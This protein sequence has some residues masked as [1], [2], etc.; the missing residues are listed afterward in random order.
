LTATA[1]T[2]ICA[3]GC[4]SKK[5]AFFYAFFIGF[6]G[7]GRFY[8]GYYIGIL[9]LIIGILGCIVPV[10]MYCWYKRKTDH[11]GL[12]IVAMMPI[13]LMVIMCTTATFIW[14]LVDWIL[15][16]ANVLTDAAGNP[17]YNDF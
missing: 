7:A 10:G 1:T 4:L 14:W 12:V 13:L 3:D 16:L 6:F 8:L 11:M 5:T 2:E 9:Q 17:L 15:I